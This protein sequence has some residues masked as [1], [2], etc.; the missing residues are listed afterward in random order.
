MYRILV[1]TDHQ[2]W[3]SPERYPKVHQRFAVSDFRASSPT[4]KPDFLLLVDD[5][6]LRDQSQKVRDVAQNSRRV[7]LPVVAVGADP[8]VEDRSDEYFLFD[9]LPESPTERDLLRSARNATRFLK[10]ERLLRESQAAVEQR[11]RE[12]EQLNAIGIALS[13]ERDH[14]KLL[15]LILSKSRQITKADAGSLFLVGSIDER[16]GLEDEQGDQARAQGR[17]LVFQMAQNDSREFRFIEEVLEI[18]PSS[19]AGYVA[20]T[21]KILNIADAYQMD[22]DIPFTIN[23]NFDET[24]GYRSRSM[25][26]VPM[27]NREGEA[28][29]VLQLINKKKDAGTR[30]TTQESFENDILPF[31]ALDELLLRS[32][33]SQA[34]ISVEN[35]T[36]YQKIETLFDGFVDAA[37]L[38]IESRDPVTQ[39]HSKRVA[40]MTVEL[41]QVAN[42]TETGAYGSLYLTG[43]QIR[44]LKYAALLHDFGKVGVKEKVLQKERKLLSGELAL[45]RERFNTIQRTIEAE[46]LR[47]MLDH[48]LKEGDRSR[49]ELA[50]LQGELAKEL[51]EIDRA[52]DEVE[53]TNQPTVTY[54][55]GF[56]RVE[57]IARRHYTGLDG[58]PRRFLEQPE[59]LA[60]KIPLGTLTPEERA[61]VEEHVDH[62][63]EFLSK[64]PWTRD[65]QSIPKLARAHH[66]KLD[67][68][69]YP[70]KLQG[71]EIA[72]Q[73]RMMTISDIFDALTAQDRP[74]KPRI[75]NHAALDILREDAGEGKLDA[76]LLEL[77]I[78][79]KVFKSTVPHPR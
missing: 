8:N 29:G 13:A 23:R 65:L 49:Q 25:L 42:R 16:I 78:E 17:W 1:W 5:A 11:A 45:V 9:I 40:K 30:L 10:S 50:R 57:E 77:F 7:P 58:R 24:S 6:I 72:P 32:L 52:W 66:L 68:S 41:A 21:G 47:R 74:Y 14:D 12:L 73:T 63:F 46:Y 34:A 35:N 15:K 64:I 48:L 59:L 75:P 76:E 39:G 60:L 3:L 51:A 54:F 18:A 27:Q 62:T 70:R 26:V 37:V 2:G 28:I 61:Q 43:E 67:G 56:E 55:S 20:Q 53:S 71:I 79:A 44:E 33:A 19:I 22:P 4:S 38:A 36:L 69:G 31:T